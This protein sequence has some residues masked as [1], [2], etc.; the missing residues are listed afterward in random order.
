MDDCARRMVVAKSCLFLQLR[1]LNEESRKTWTYVRHETRDI[2]HVSI[3]HMSHG[4]RS[5]QHREFD[6][7]N[8][9]GRKFHWTSLDSKRTIKRQSHL[10]IYYDSVFLQSIPLTPD[11]LLA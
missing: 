9:T 8:C 2:G 3:C 1:A 4:W 11:L 7:I 6:R 10:L 5:V